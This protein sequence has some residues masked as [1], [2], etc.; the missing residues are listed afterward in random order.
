MPLLFSGWARTSTPLSKGPTATSLPPISSF[1]WGDSNSGTGGPVKAVE[2]VRVGTREEVSDDVR[3][4]D[5]A[6]VSEGVSDGVKEEEGDSAVKALEELKACSC[7]PDEVLWIARAVSAPSASGFTVCT[8][9]KC[10][11]ACCMTPPPAP[12]PKPV[13]RTCAPMSGPAAKMSGST[14]LA[15]PRDDPTVGGSMVRMPALTRDMS[16][17]KEAEPV[18][19]EVPAGAVGAP[20]GTLENKEERSRLLSSVPTEPGAVAV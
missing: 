15:P 5:S 13:S 6:D 8:S 3:D 19:A 1:G 17:V 14:V 9:S 12:E 18:G 20:E 2:D 11:V 7:S 10:S 4:E 16:M